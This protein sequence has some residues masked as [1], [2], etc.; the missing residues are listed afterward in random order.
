LGTKDQW[1]L[2]ESK[3]AW[4]NWCMTGGVCLSLSE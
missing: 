1:V 2:W 4:H 3:T